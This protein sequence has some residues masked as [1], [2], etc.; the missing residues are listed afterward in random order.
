[1]VHLQNNRG[2]CGAGTGEPVSEENEGVRSKHREPDY[3]KDFGSYFESNESNQK[4][5][6]K[7]LTQ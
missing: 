4:F 5:L 6:T 1:M 2:R 7:E 3:R